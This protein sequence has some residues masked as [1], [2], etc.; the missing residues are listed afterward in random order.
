MS[1]RDTVAQGSPRPGRLG[2]RIPPEDEVA[3]APARPYVGGVGTNR[4]GGSVF[5]AGRRSSGHQVSHSPRQTV[6]GAS[7]LARRSECVSEK[8]PVKGP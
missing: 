4:N 3:A 5:S 7:L 1:A 2:R 8:M 6:T